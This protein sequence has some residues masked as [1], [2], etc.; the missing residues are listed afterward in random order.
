MKAAIVGCGYVG[1]A[2]AQK[3]TALGFNVLA[4]T[5][6]P[7]R[8]EE[9]Q[10]LA[11]QVVVLTGD[12]KT[13]L[14][15]ALSDRDIVLLCVGSKRGASYQQTYLGTAQTLAAVLPQTQVKQLIYT[16]TCSIYGQTHGGWVDETVP[17][18]PTSTNGQ[19]IEQTEQTLLS[20]AASD[21]KICILRL[22]GIYGPG[23][24]LARIYG[25]I[26]GTTRPG[27]G[28]EIANWVHLN[29]IVNA[30]D[31]ARSQQLSGIYNLVQDELIPRR[32]LITKVCE[33]NDLSPVQW[34][35]N[36]PSPPNRNVRLSN[37]KI[38]DTGYQ[39]VHP[40][41]GL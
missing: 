34:D 29:D 40:A 2:I 22:G 37:Q 3:W 38:K 13:K 32:E 27:T 10:Q 25:R 9:L 12:D 31:W 41:F 24:T 26:A 4:T 17:P 1:K 20:A 11:S 6:S 28:E 39:F 30:I 36:P 18:A 23:R 15:F 35:N 7:E 19:V 21:R 33:K 5:T 16:S 8:I 14:K